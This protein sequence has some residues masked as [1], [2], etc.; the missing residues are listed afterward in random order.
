MTQFQQMEYNC[1]LGVD[2]PNPITKPN[3]YQPGESSYNGPASN[4][5]SGRRD[6]KSKSRKPNNSRRN[7]HQKY[8]MKSVK[9]GSFDIK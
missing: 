8:E 5:A 4:N 3:S 7:P 9:Q 6:G 2:Y 1:R